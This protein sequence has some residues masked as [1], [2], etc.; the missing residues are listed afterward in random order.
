MHHPTAGLEEQGGLDWPRLAGRTVG[1]PPPQCDHGGMDRPHLRGT[2]F[3]ANR[4]FVLPA[5]DSPPIVGSCVLQLLFVYTAHTLWRARV[6]T[7]HHGRNRPLFPIPM[8]RV[9]MQVL[10]ILRYTW[11]TRP[12]AT[13]QPPHLPPLR[14]EVLGLE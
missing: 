1:V 4:A 3:L 5:E 10:S 8:N 14:A 11:A 9:R 2:T 7:L 12:E 13:F 6:D